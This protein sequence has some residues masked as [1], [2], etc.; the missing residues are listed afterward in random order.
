MPFETVKAGEQY[1]PSATEHNAFIAAALAHRE[2]ERSIIVPGGK[3]DPS[4]VWIKNTESSD[5]DALTVMALDN[6]VSDKWPE[7][8]RDRIAFNGTQP[9]PEVKPHH[10]YRVAVL[11]DKIASGEIGVG[12]IAGQITM[13]VD[14]VDVLHTRAR[15]LN[16]GKLQSGYFGPFRILAAKE[17][18]EAKL[19][20]VLI[21]GYDGGHCI[22]EG[23]IA[24]GTYAAP[25]VNESMP[26]GYLDPTT[27]AAAMLASPYNANPVTVY[28]YGPAI[29]AAKIQCRLICGRIVPD[30]AYCS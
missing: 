20:R 24:E 10:R 3:L 27:G 29:A 19:C 30:V 7:S 6:P 26:L 8:L 1:T 15:V 22:V 11:A 25:S 13:P 17:V 12:F 9:V 16:N 5:Q 28:H 23:S 4:A 21:D 18:G 14:V 2:N